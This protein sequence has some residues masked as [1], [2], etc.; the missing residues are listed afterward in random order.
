MGKILPRAGEIA[1]QISGIYVGLT[2]LCALSYRALGMPA[3]EA[4]CM[5]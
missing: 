3:F 1:Q 2:L 4:T 5:R